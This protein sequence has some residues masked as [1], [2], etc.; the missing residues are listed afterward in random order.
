MLV[1]LLVALAPCVSLQGAQP[2]ISREDLQVAARVVGLTF[3]DAEAELALEGVRE[4]LASYER[5]WG[6][7]VDNSVAPML[8]S[9]A[10]RTA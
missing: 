6:I 2:G 5:L 9:R 1:S 3:S 7:E 4:N 8:S 10:I